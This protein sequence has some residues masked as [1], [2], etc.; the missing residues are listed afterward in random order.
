MCRQVLL[1]AGRDAAGR[2]QPPLL[3]F[4]AAVAAS[5]LAL[6][7][8][9]PP[10]HPVL[11]TSPPPSPS[12]PGGGAVADPAADPCAAAELGEAQEDRLILRVNDALA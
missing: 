6:Y 11:D 12:T 1:A 2:Y 4:A 9:P 3:V 8:C 7:F 10:Q 5:G